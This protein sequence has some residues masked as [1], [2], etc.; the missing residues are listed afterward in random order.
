MDARDGH[1]PLPSPSVPLSESL[2]SF[3]LTT[4]T[5][6]EQLAPPRADS[7]QPFATTP[8]TA[9]TYSRFELLPPE[10]IE[11]VA[12]CLIRSSSNQ[13]PPTGLISLLLV[14]K[15]FEHVL[16][17]KRNKGFYADLFKERFDTRA[18]ERRWSTMRTIEEKRE[19]LHLL[20]TL[21]ESKPSEAIHLNPGSSFT[22]P[23]SPTAFSLDDDDHDYDRD[24]GVRRGDDSTGNSKPNDAYP[25]TIPTS[26]WDPLTNRDYA[27]ELV[28]RCQVLTKMR[29]AAIEGGFKTGTSRPAS[30]RLMSFT[31]RRGRTKL[32]EPDELTQN[33]WTCYLMLLENDGKNLPHLLEYACLRE[34][35]RLFYRHSLL[36]EALN[37]GWPRQTAG[38]ALGL[39]IGWLGGDDVASETAQE[40]EERF[41]VL[42]PYVFAA[43]KF[44][45]FMAPWTIRSLP[46]THEAFPVLPPPAGPYLADLRPRSH[47]QTITHMGRKLDLSP[48]NLSHAAIFSFFFR[49][50]QDPSV[51]NDLLVQGTGT[52]AQP[53]QFPPNATATTGPSATGGLTAQSRP[54]K[55]TL[56]ALKSRVHDRDFVRLASCIDPYH[57]RGL[58]TKY[59]QGDL[60]GNW[61]GRFSFFDFDSYRDM[62]GGR[63]RSLYEGPFGDQPQVWKLE[64]R[65]VK[66]ERTTSTI[67]TS[68][69]TTSAGIKDKV[70]ASMTNKRG[71]NTTTTIGGTGP[72]L[73]AGFEYHEPPLSKS[74]HSQSPPPPTVR[75]RRPSSSTVSTTLAGAVEPVFAEI[76]MEDSSATSECKKGKKR[77]RRESEISSGELPYWPED[78]EVFDEWGRSSKR[79]TGHDHRDLED[80]DYEI[81]LTGSGHSAWG[82][83]NLKGRVRAWD[84]MF[85][86]IKEYTPDSRGRWIYRGYR[87]GDSLV[88]RWRDTHTPVDMNGYEGTWSM[89]RRS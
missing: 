16:S 77:T 79:G 43:H 85:T 61:E 39:W 56:P 1:A 82:Q 37:P 55:T 66:L 18:I 69:K 2:S 6:L 58:P 17:F 67:T 24:H 21:P 44:D 49:V 25:K 8:P 36:A 70:A 53:V 50:E 78:E 47:A 74:T 35:M 11:Q 29:I 26:P 81:L 15:R 40:S 46:V 41:F 89:N 31:P 62:L 57:S 48:P 87:I 7:S 72:V 75:R 9:R 45:A 76:E 73:N 10:L 3:S 22:R 4:N 86:I 42:K 27:I 54:T 19:K 65:I 20:Q 84:G 38:R 12:F 30:P 5:P 83:F 80:G 33:L 52:P 88:G 51:Q 63:M 60:E 68:S 34:Y 23:S 71:S 14:S 59:T 64:E 28:R 32:S 13:G